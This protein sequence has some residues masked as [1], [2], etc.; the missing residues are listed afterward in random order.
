LFAG[1]REG[2]TQYFW[3][4][5]DFS[6]PTSRPWANMPFTDRVSVKPRPRRAPQASSVANAESALVSAL[7]QPQN[8]G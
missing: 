4:E 3:P 6:M 8:L 7:Y 1:T 5:Y 2:A